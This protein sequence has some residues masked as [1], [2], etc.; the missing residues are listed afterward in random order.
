MAYRIPRAT[1]Y[2]VQS[3]KYK[4]RTKDKGQNTVPIRLRLTPT[5]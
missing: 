5:I 1:K 2:K 4:A 3:T